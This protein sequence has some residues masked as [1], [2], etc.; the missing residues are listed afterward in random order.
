MSS[1]SHLCINSGGKWTSTVDDSDNDGFPS[2]GDRI[3]VEFDD[4]QVDS[5]ALPTDGGFTFVIDDVDFDSGDNIIGLVVE[6]RYDELTVGS[7]ASLDGAFVAWQTLDDAGIET[8]RFSYD[9]VQ[10]TTPDGSAIYNV[11]IE[12]EFAGSVNTYA[13][14]GAITLGNQTFQIIQGPTWFRANQSAIPSRGLIYLQDFEGDRL[15]MEAS[16]NE[17]LDFGFIPAGSTQP[18][19]V[20]LDQRWSDFGI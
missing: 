7:A 18:T 8:Y 3:S 2:R 19:F 11:D 15:S 17:R 1:D 9:D 13:I 5:L 6:G 10:A 16:S 4:C 14:D 20:L 12:G